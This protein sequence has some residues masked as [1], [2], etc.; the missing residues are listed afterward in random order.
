MFLNIAHE[1]KLRD[2]LS[3]KP[4]GSLTSAARDVG[5][6]PACVCPSAR[7]QRTQFIIV[8]GQ[9]TMLRQRLLNSASF[10]FREIS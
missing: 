8:A 2:S 10:Y 5:A 7:H 3:K 1:L 9:A 6:C 4:F